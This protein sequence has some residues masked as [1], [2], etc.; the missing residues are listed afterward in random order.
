MFAFFNDSL[1]PKIYVT[2]NQNINPNS[3]KQFTTTW[4]NF[5]LKKQPYTLLFDLAGLGLPHLTYAIKISYFIESLKKRKKL[6]NNVYLT[7]SIIICNNTYQR[8]LLEWVFFIQS[9]VAPVY[10]VKT[11]EEAE[12]LYTNLSFNKHFYLSTVTAYFPK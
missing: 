6:L 9:P 12:Q 7:K 2:F 8:K 5:D 1:F 10:I 4:R 3:W 11:T